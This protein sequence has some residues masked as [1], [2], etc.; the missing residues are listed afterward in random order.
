M[1]RKVKDARCAFELI[2]DNRHRSI[3][4]VLSSMKDLPI[5][6]WENGKP[7]YTNQCKVSR[8]LTATTCESSCGIFKKEMHGNM[9][10]RCGL[11]CILHFS[12]DICLYGD[13]GDTMDTAREKLMQRIDEVYAA[14]DA[15]Y[16]SLQKGNIS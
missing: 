8:Y 4:I 14:L 16:A 9:F 6:L 2:W 12:T 1:M 13:N 11:R 15:A 7:Q 5:L 10:E 3:S